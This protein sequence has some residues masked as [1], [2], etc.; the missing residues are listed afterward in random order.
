MNLK[1]SL[2]LIFSLIS[3]PSSTWD[4]LSIE[5]ESSAKGD[6]RFFYLLLIINFAACFVGNLLNGDNFPLVFSSLRA[7][8]YAISIYGG[9]WTIYYILTEII[10]NRFHVS[11]SKFKTNR[12]IYYSFVLF[13]TINIL[14]ALLPDIL[15]FL[16]IGY[17]YTL[18]IVWEASGKF[19]PELNENDRSNFVLLLSSSIILIPIVIEQ[20][21][22]FAVPAAR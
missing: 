11:L 3:S 22:I 9:Y 4:E 6:N 5:P 13:L 19:L 14:T 16:K 17:I 15:F 7:I 2:K 20:I 8:I 1:T 18:Y 21:L 10:F 12:L